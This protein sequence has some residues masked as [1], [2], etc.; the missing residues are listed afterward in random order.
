MIKNDVRL[1]ALDL[2]GTVLRSNNTLADE[3]KASV[4]AAIAH[5]IEVVVASGRPYISMPKEI[6]AIE[7]INYVVASN[8]AAVYDGSGRRVISMPMKSDD[9]LRLLRLT[10]DYDLIWEAFLEGETC[11]DRRYYEDPVSYGCS[12]AYV[13]YV[14][15]SRGCSN[16][17]RG[18]ILSHADCLDSVEF[19]CSDAALREPLRRMLERELDGLY[20][21]SSSADFVEF[22]DKNATKS[23]AVRSIC[24][25][26]SI[27]LINTAACGNADNDVDMIAQAGLGAAV[28]NATRRCLDAAD[29]TVSSN[30]DHGVKELIEMIIR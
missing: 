17:M 6:L 20:I 25:L 7:G 21:T 16:D 30:N 5:G 4:E 15:S 19:V 1:L 12:E 14:R 28:K 2:D 23:N 10:E 27:P 24:K 8:G 22:M 13:D 26:E 9:V 3:V 18:Y 29:I 11:T